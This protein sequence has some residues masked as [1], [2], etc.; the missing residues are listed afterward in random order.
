MEL[1]KSKPFC[2]FLLAVLPPVTRRHSRVTGY[3]KRKKRE[4]AGKLIECD[5][6]VG[7]RAPPSSVSGYIFLHPPHVRDVRR[8][9]LYRWNKAPLR[10][11]VL[12]AERGRQSFAQWKTP[13]GWKTE[14]RSGRTR[15]FAV[16]L[17]TPSH[18]L[19]SIFLRDWPNTRR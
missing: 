7:R 5:A 3:R 17:K 13:G 19:S 6:H 8:L 15:H 12:A 4:N 9:T 18:F 16:L 2:S 14:T 1:R 11:N 10:R